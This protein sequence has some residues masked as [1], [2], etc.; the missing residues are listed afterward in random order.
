MQ[1][2]ESDLT[3]PE[4]PDRIFV[5]GGTMGELMRGLDW[6]AT[7][8]GPVENWP[9]SLKTTISTCLDSR[10]AIIVWWGPEMVILYNDSYSRILG[11]KHPAAL[12]RPGREIWSEVWHIVG[13]MLRGVME[14]S[15]AT[16]SDNLL[17]ELERSGYREECYFTFSYSP[18]RDESGGVGG[19]FTPV[20]ETTDQVIG[21]RRLRTLRDLAEAARAAN[22][23]SSAE[24]CR[25]ACFTLEKNSYDIPFAAFYFIAENGE[26]RLAASVGVGT[27]NPLFPDGAR[28]GEPWA[29]GRAFECNGPATVALPLDLKDVPCGAWPVPAREVLVFPISPA[30]QNIG[31]AILAVSPRKRLDEV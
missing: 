12:G 11:V 6:S 31:F 14:R 25:L 4:S 7:P 1:P 29:F 21:E 5:G 15:E 9:Q 2:A 18:I 16:W 26:A 13:P 22:A 24:V 17:L 20:Q 8:L 30:G 27:A 10:F 28:S 3:H 23:E 19:I